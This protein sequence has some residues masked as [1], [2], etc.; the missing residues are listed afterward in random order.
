METSIFIAR[1]IAPVMVAA[2]AAVLINPKFL[3]DVAKDIIDNRGL[4]FMAGIMAL[5]TG[6]A[7][8]NVHNVWVAGWPVI[9]TIFG[10]L[11]IVGG[12]VRIVFPDLAIAMAEKMLTNEPLTR[13]IAVGVTLF[14]LWFGWVAYF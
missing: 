10:W 8:V 14:G 4:L 11:A 12:V 3:N 6:V 5:V 13:I 7:I 9:I 2:G 1:L